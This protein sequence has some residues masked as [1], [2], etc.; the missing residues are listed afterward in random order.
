MAHTSTHH[1][2]RPISFG[3]IARSA[4]HGIATVFGGFWNFMVRIAE[5]NGRAKTVE[6]L[7]MMSDAELAKRGIKREDIVR[8]VFKDMFY[9]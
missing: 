5:T 1:T 4:G 2:A 9:L 6:R 7:S 8:H 3:G